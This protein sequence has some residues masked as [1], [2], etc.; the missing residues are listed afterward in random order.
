VYRWFIKSKVF[1]LSAMEA[2]VGRRGIL[3]AVKGGEWSASC[4][5]CA[6]PPG[7]GPLICIVQ[8]AVWVA[9]DAEVSRKIL[10]LCRGSNS[11][12]QVY[13]TL[14]ELPGSQRWFII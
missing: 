5:G 12:C 1:P 9:L 7:K 4:L 13:T 8:E 11:G 3:L 6:L 10:G 2:L 14:T